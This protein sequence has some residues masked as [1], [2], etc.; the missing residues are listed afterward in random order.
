MLIL[1]Q[2]R[3]FPFFALILIIGAIFFFSTTAYAADTNLQAADVSAQSA[4]PDKE[5]IT[6][7]E[8]TLAVKEVWL[9]GDTLHINV[10]ERDTDDEQMLELNLLDYAKP[11]DEY[12]T[13]Q[14]PTTA[15][16]LPTR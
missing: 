14:A 8:A 10:A 2:N 12:V 7:V 6:P 13:V 11:A 16:E 3:Q 15:V 5:S 9:T 4:K 1:K